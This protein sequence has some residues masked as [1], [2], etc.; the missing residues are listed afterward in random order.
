MQGFSRKITRSIKIGGVTIGGSAPIVVQSMT[1][2]D[3]RDVEAT[4]RQI[5]ELEKNGC[6]VVRLAVVD[7]EAAA[8]LKK[9]KQQ[10]SIPLIADIH[11]NYRLALE[12][13]D[14]GVDGLR[15]NPG[16]I[17]ERSRVEMVTQ[18]AKERGIPIRIGVN[19]GSLEKSLLDK[20]GGVTAE[21]LVESALNHVRILE[22]MKFYDIKISIKASHVP[23][24]IKAYQKI[25]SC[26]DYPL[27]LGVTEAGTIFTGTIKSAIGIGALLA[28]GIGDTIR[29]SLTG[30][31]VEEVRVG[32]EILKGLGLRERGPE[33]ISCPT[34]GRCQ[35]NLFSI[36]EKVERE[37]QD[38]KTPLKVAIMGCVV[39]GPGEARQADIGLAG[40][41]DMGLLF[42]KGK[43]LRKI[44]QSEMVKELVEEIR[45]MDESQ[46]K[47]ADGGGILGE[48]F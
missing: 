39:N 41:K 31:P 1:K 47:A 2:T 32:Y 17:G 36:V 11:F 29:V 21:A 24:M 8:A 42:K 35:I 26:V 9:I 14:N 30:P 15:I 3:T 46:E 25:S 20:Y 7:M 6:E 38:I 5:K 13:I 45:K 43:V 10:T 48:S 40:G 33:I 18:R 4:V 28:Q 16:N 27:H 19:A 23:L 44:K 34:C 22:N 37:I 12:C